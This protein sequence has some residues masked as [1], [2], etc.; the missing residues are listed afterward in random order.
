MKQGKV[1]KELKDAGDRDTKSKQ[2][3]KQIS[4]EIKRIKNGLALSST[5]IP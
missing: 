2:P 5:L 3:Q 4:S 1:R